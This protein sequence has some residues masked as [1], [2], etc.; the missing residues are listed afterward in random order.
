MRYFV[1]PA[2]KG[3]KGLPFKN[4]KLFSFTASSIPEGLRE[5]VIVSTDDEEIEKSA[6]EWGFSLLKRSESLSV[7]DVSIRDVL[8]DVKSHFKM[9]ENDDIIMLYLTYP[10]RTF[11]DIKGIY[12]FYKQSSAN[13]LLCKKEA[14]TTPYLCYHEVGKFNGEKIIEHD[15]YRRQ[16]YP[17]CFEVSHYVAIMK[18]GIVDKL[19]NN[20]YQKDTVFYSIDDVIDVDTGEDFKR[21]IIND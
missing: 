7:D 4:R 20:L 10:Q 1:I 19:D 21:F 12:D 11:E 5:S 17:K 14:K 3:S 6:K 16:D 2:R 18:A 8:S 15:L 9:Q 13:S